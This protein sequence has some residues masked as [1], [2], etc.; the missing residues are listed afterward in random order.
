MKRLMAL[1][2]GV[3]IF[4]AACD[5]GAQGPTPEPPGAASPAEALEA[6]ALAFN[7][8]DVK[9]LASALGENFVFYFDPLDVGQRPPWN[10]EYVIPTSWPRD[11]F[12]SAAKNMLDDAYSINL[13][14]PTGS[15]GTPAEN[16]ATY[17]AEN[18]PLH[19]VVMVDEVNG[20][21]VD[22]GYC[23][24]EFERYDAGGKKCWRLTK[25][26]DRTSWSCDESLALIPTS[27]GRLLAIF[28]REVKL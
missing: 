17:W 10:P 26:V 25:W 28:K 3:G 13:K 20:F 9:V 27:L 24:Y 14:I 21:I 8:R 16:E 19:L 15:V 4:A 12:R 2:V 23:N 6:V 22:N 18:V 7:R 1:C 11:E 5:D